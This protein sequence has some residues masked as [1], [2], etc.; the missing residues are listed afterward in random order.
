MDALS[1]LPAAIPAAAPDDAKTRLRGAA[2]EFEAIFL[3]QILAEAR[4]A[5]PAGEDALFGGQ[6]MDTF[7]QMQDER[8][9][10][11]AADSGAIGLAQALEAQIAAVAG[12]D[13]DTPAPTGKAG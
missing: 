13:R 11:I 7:N 2:R 6:A 12:L 8:I 4:K 5:R 3:R 10:A 9:A 1:A